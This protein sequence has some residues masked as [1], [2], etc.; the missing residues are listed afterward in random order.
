MYFELITGGAGSGKSEYIEQRISECVSEGKRAIVIVPERFS[1]IEERTLCE[2]FG[3]LGI[4][5]VEVSTFSK[6]TR[7]LRPR[8]EY[9]KPS[10]RQ[11]LILKAARDNKSAGDGV[12]ESAAERSGFAE[13][14]GE[15]ISEF[16]RCLVSPQMLMEYE[17]SSLLGK[18]INALGAIYYGYDKLL[19]GRF[20]DPDEDLELL[21]AQ[22][23]AEGGFGDA[24]IFIDGFTDFLPTH[25]AVISAL[26]Q[27]ADKLYCVLTI[28]DKT[29][30]GD[31]I[32][33]PADM[34]CSKL[35]DNAKELGANIKR[36]HFDNSLQHIKSPDLKY[37]IANYDELVHTDECPKC[38]NISVVCLADRHAEV[39]RLAGRIM[40][41][42]RENGLR[43]RD[44]GVIVGDA[45]KY[46]HIIDAVFNDCGIPYFADRKMMISEH[47]IVRLV[48]SIFRIINENWS[49]SAVFEYLRSGFI[50]T[51]DENGVCVMD[52][53][54][55]DRLDD[56][57]QKYGIRGKKAW[58]SDEVW[59]TKKAGLFDEITKPV[60]EEKEAEQIDA[61]RRELML[62]FKKF[63]EKIKGRRRVR[64][65]AAALFE[66]LCDINLYEGLMVEQKHLENK[67]R[68][69][70]AARLGEVWNGLIETLDQCVT[71]LGD[72]FISREAFARMLLAGLSQCSVD[73]VPSGADRVSVGTA[74]QTRPVRVDT[75]FVIGAVYGELPAEGSDGGILND[76]D[77]V[78]LQ[79]SGI[80]LLPSAES[81]SALSEF[82]LY[83]SL[84]AAC[85]RLY[86][87]FPNSGEGGE[88]NAPCT[89]IEE[90]LRTFDDLEI[91]VP[92]EQEEWE[93]LFCSKKRTY[94]KM[95][96]RMV[97]NPN[98]EE[99]EFWLGILGNP[100]YVYDGGYE[101][102][103]SRSARFKTENEHISPE[104][105]MA[106]YQGRPF[107]ITALQ[108]YN[109][110]PFAYFVQYGL[111]VYAREEYKLKSYDLGQLVHWAVCEFC[112]K[113]QEDAA[114]LD[115]VKMRW[116]ELTK[117]KAGEIISTLGEY[118]EET[119]KRANPDYTPERLSMMCRRAV[120]TISE[121]VDTIRNSLMCGSFASCNF[122]KE[123]EF[124]INHKDDSVDIRGV[125]DRVDIAKVGDDALLRV[126]DYKT[127]AQKFS[128]AGIYNKTDLQLMIYA[129]AAKKLY[130]NGE[131]LE[132]PEG[133]AKVAA[134]LYNKVR[135]DTKKAEINE[136]CSKKGILDGIVVTEGE[137]SDTSAEELMVHDRALG[138]PS[139]K[140][141]YL[142]IE[143]VAKGGLRVGNG[144]V[145]RA[146]FEVLERYAAKTACDTKSAIYAGD[147]ASIPAGKDRS[148][149]CNFCD[150]AS[151]C[152]HSPSRD[153]ERELISTAKEAW[154]LLLAEEGADE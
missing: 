6:L 9:L 1:H 95:L 102:I 149:A 57:V 122:E 59:K 129:L 92:T 66:F 99:C 96:S 93:N 142:P 82:K 28:D 100:E 43:F 86:V 42:V 110:C 150:F 51:K 21:A 27:R 61:L 105:A 20:A 144:A 10:G 130:Q 29:G 18:K 140:S 115:E 24:Q 121:A 135:E 19:E 74:E 35:L 75:L 71:T 83:S 116:S 62:P 118:I 111:G 80:E 146:K 49:R 136:N 120:S 15:A 126:I 106:L 104:T 152:L 4:N 45:D 112:Q 154:E 22:I 78:N 64:E 91:T 128:V 37:F 25:F 46:T 32:F 108:T 56:F 40:Y 8:G 50:F 137:P 143:T 41:E 109:K 101:D 113:V 60:S 94:Y 17:S 53:R 58:L 103:L 114:T 63:C 87:S 52:L 44:I 97:Q 65:I 36:T 79:N 125:I 67:N 7:R 77:R 84:T 26:L 107:S 68:M 70:D 117:Q 147:I 119:A 131:L 153:K 23:I 132:N 33:A 89:L 141:E 48:L 124:T 134:V 30:R 12:F 54:K 39:E 139:T 3:G 138:N 73:A 90:L 145:S 5:G 2:K 133:D 55:I 38:D 16:K 151:V 123:F 127:G 81:R 11:M 13:R 69:D 85:R 14:V 76:I 34:C 148:S 31:G 72:E 88:K 47:P 98:K